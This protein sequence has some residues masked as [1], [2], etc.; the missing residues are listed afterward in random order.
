MIKHFSIFL[1]IAINVLLPFNTSKLKADDLNRLLNEG[2]EKF[3]EKDYD[4]AI[5]KFDKVIKK[6]PEN[7]EAYQNRG[8][9]KRKL[10]DFEGSIIDFT[11]A[12]ELNLN[13]W[14]RS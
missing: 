6:D 13:P 14:F 5:N 2:R 7:W 9:S 4:E 10:K 8:L 12:I 1:F 3:I 11:K